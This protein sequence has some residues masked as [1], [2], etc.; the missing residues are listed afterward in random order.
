MGLRAMWLPIV[1]WVSYLLPNGVGLVQSL[2]E[3]RDPWDESQR[4][5][6]SFGTQ[7]QHGEMQASL[8]T[9]F[10]MYRVEDFR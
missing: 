6:N 3:L 5:L 9:N 1:R 10:G 2:R 8:R 4:E 7:L